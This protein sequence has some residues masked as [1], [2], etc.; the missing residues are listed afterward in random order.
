MN[1][2]LTLR[3]FVLTVVVVVSILGASFWLVMTQANSK[4]KQ[5]Q[6]KKVDKLAFDKE[7]VEVIKLEV[8][9]KALKLGEHFSG[10]EEWL[11]SLSINIKNVSGKPI[12]YIEVWLDFPETKAT[13]STMSF[14]IFYGQ[15]PW[16]ER[17]SDEPKLVMP[18]DI[19][20]IQMSDVTYAAL[21][22]F[23]ENRHS[24]KN[25]NKVQLRI[26]FVGFTDGTAWDS[27]NLIRPDPNNP[28][29]Y[30][31]IDDPQGAAMNR[32]AFSFKEVNYSSGYTLTRL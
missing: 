17:T 1:K 20:A 12:S 8:E 28:K 30:I 14:P 29:K 16:I 26:S 10:E 19:V 13:G 7:P 9:K 22:R 5:S 2:I 4:T 21:K 24:I 18:N 15:R 6:E 27:G 23:V 32:S 3:R 25:L 11:K 31:S